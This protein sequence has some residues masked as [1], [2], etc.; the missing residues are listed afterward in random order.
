MDFGQ[1]KIL[2]GIDL[3]EF[4]IPEEYGQTL[5]SKEKCRIT[6]G[7]LAILEPLLEKHGIHA[8]F[9]T[10]A[11]WAQQAKEKVMELARDHEIASHGFFHNYFELHHLRQSREL[12]S[13]F[14]GQEVIGL[15]VPRMRCLPYD[16][17]AEAGYLYDSS[18]NPTYLPNRYNHFREPRNIFF[19]DGIY[20]MPAS[21]SRNLRIPL[22]WLSFKNLP[23]LY[24]T[25]LC[26][27]VLRE[28]G[29]LIIYLH[30]WEF[31]DL[32][33]YQLP[34]YIKRRGGVAMAQRTDRLFS[35]LAKAGVF[36][37]HREI[38]SVFSREDGGLTK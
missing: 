37:T 19:R 27:R 32:S 15:R 29:Y 24:Y 7:G 17:I 13:E 22:F 11:C 23:F 31:M 20:E 28:I 9:F 35:H 16:E 12:L 2:L 33:G 34:W 10:T 18:L 3:E 25:R 36:T 1:K 6:R 4:D 5:S 26:D 14:S 21:V 30:P 8:T 38:V